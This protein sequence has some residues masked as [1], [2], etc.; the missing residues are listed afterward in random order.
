MALADGGGEVVFQLSPP[1]LRATSRPLVQAWAVIGWGDPTEGRTGRH[2]NAGVEQRNVPAVEVE[3]DGGEDVAASGHTGRG[4]AHKK[5]T[6]R[7]ELSSQRL[8][9]G[10]GEAEGEVLVEQHQCGGAIRA[11]APQSG[12]GRNGFDEVEVAGRNREVPLKKAV[13]AHDEVVLCRA[14]NGISSQMQGDVV[15]AARGGDFDRVAPRNGQEQAVQFVEPIGTPAAD[16][17]PDIDFGV[18]EGD[19]GRLAGINHRS[20]HIA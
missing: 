3:V 13:G 14:C 20:S 7:T 18:G 11:A 15:A 12:A 17:K 8:Q 9:L 16:L 19:T 6:V 1:I 4:V 2:V 5:G 10:S